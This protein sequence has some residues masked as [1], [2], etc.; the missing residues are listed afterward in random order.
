LNATASALKRNMAKG[1]G[2]EACSLANMLLGFWDEN[3]V[4]MA[5]KLRALVNEANGK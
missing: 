4:P 2:S 3:I 5:E 1:E